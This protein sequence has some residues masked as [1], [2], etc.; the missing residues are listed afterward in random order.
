[1]LY[2]VRKLYAKFYRL[3]FMVFLNIAEIRTSA[4]DCLSSNDTDY[5]WG[6]IMSLIF[7]IFDLCSVAHKRRQG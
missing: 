4:I 6:V 5:K 7:I 2:R 1:M 3:F